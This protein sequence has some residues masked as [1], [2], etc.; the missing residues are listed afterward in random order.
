MNT[1]AHLNAAFGA[2]IRTELFMQD[3]ITTKDNEKIKLNIQHAIMIKEAKSS[4]DILKI[5]DIAKKNKL[6]ISE[7]TRE[8]IK[9]TDDTKVI[10]MTK[11]KNLKEVEYLGVLIFGKKTSVEKLTKEYELYS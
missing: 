1:I 7:F 8:M 6:D 2:R 3:E 4:K 11:E 5:I 9:T 10:S